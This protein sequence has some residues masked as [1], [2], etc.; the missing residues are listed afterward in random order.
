MTESAPD[1]AKLLPYTGK[2]FLDSLDEVEIVRPHGEADDISMGAAAEA[3]KERLV[4]DDVERGRLL[5]M[6]RA[7]S[8]KFAPSARKPNSPADQPGE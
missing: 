2:E 3:M 4:L 1:G 5:V 7:Q 6:K 8:G